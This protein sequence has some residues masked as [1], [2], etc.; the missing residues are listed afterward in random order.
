[1]DSSHR[2]R[3]GIR[4]FYLPQN[5]WLA[6]HH[7]IQAGG[8]AKQMSYGFAL[9]VLVKMWLVLR[10]VELKIIPQESAQVGAPVLSLSQHL[11][12]IAGAQ[13]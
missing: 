4:L 6:H 1:M 5:L 10:W 13:D 12:A 7:G 3:R 11:D 2:A 9:A 8:H